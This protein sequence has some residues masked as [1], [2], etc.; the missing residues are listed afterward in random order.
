M[1]GGKNVRRVPGT[2]GEALDELDK[3][4]I[5]QSALPG[6][7]LK[8]FMHYKRDE[9]TRFIATVTDWDV[10]EYLDILP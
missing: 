7:M 9:W 3:D 2:L 10:K 1:A 6:E 4:P 8:V 5:V